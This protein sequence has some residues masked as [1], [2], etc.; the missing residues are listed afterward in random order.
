MVDHELREKI[1]KELKIK[2][3]TF[4]ILKRLLSETKPIAGRLF[5][6]VI[7]SVIS[8]GV[9]LLSPYIIGNLTEVLNQY[10]TGV[11]QT[12]DMNALVAGCLILL[13]GYCLK[14]GA[15]LGKVIIM[16]NTVSR[17][18]TAT[19]RVRISDKIKRLPVSYI[20]STPHGEIIARTINDVSRMGT[21]VHSF[22]NMAIM[23][24]IQLIAIIVIMFTINPVIAAVI[25]VTI[26]IS[27]LIA[28]K[29]A[30]LSEK[31]Y[32]ERQKYTGKLY[33]HIE[34]HYTG[35]M[36]VKAY[37][38][39]NKREEKLSS[40]LDL[41]TAA[42]EKAF[43]YS[44]SV[45][46]VISLSNNIS[47]IIVCILGGWMAI[48]QTMNVGSIVSVVLYAR[49]LSSPFEQIASSMSMF[50]QVLASAR[51]VYDLLDYPE[52]SVTKSPVRIENVKGNVRFENIAFSYSPDK[53]LITD[54]SIDVK[55]GQKVAI[56]GPTGGGKTTLI[57][58]LMRFYDVQKGRILIDGTDTATMTREDLR[59]MFSMVLQD[60]WLF[61]GTVKEN[62]GYGKEGADDAEIIEASKQAYCDHFIKTLPH[63]YDTVLSNDM[64]SVSAG[65]KQ[66]LTIAR[67][68]LSDRKILILDEA[69]S[70]VDTRTE[71]LIQKAMDNLMK[72]RTSFVI[73]HRL[74]TIVDADIILV[75]NN[76]NIVETGTH[77]ELLAKKGF[78]SQIYN[79]QYA[80]IRN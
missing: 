11:V 21:T 39:E 5:V 60:T 61:N 80:L 3:P 7:F 19:F 66:L 8:V 75:V 17:L 36:T 14:F 6:A 41:Y 46:P 64:T 78:Y 56:V 79:S 48:N 76:G 13:T 67:A 23:G 37:N 49:Y 20:D 72:G 28:A 74:S 77:K 1:N 55:A 68:F 70:S 4:T 44:E 50:Q 54:L 73:A 38:I 63:S 69:T 31:H 59:N 58:L 47:F 12:L 2:Y 26:P 52:M 27:T 10:Y 71:I 32:S 40:I 53:P 42:N 33:A 29:I 51:R 65:Q 30:S 15:D 16:N 43:F 45:S 22:L 9:W 57:N 24:V 62:I 35:F 25:V 34:E 18:F